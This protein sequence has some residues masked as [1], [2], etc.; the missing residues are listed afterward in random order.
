ML[1]WKGGIHDN[2]IS[3]NYIS[4]ERRECAHLWCMC[5]TRLMWDCFPFTPLF[6]R[7]ALCRYRSSLPYDRICIIHVRI[8]NKTQ[9]YTNAH[10][11][12]SFTLLRCV[13]LC[14]P[15]APHQCI[16]LSILLSMYG[17]LCS[18][19][20]VCI[21]IGIYLHHSIISLVRFEVKHY[22]EEEF[23]VTSF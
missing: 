1:L 18:R 3:C 19:Y 16:S 7:C 15:A 13:Y 5:M 14:C 22:T 21:C 2:N 11:E 8:L 20:C 6:Y 9:K 12:S 23:I 4:P 17:A 10:A